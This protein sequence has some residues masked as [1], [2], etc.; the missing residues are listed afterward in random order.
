MELVEGETLGAASPAGRSRSPNALRFGLQIAEALEVA[1]ERGVIH[2]DLKPAN[3]KVTPDGRVK[4]LDFGLAEAINLP[5]AAGMSKSPTLVME[6][7]RPGTSSA[8]GVHEPEQARGRRPTAAPTSGLSAAFSSR[9]SRGAAPSRARP[10]RTRSP[11]SSTASPTGAR[12]PRARRNACAI[13]STV[14]SRRIP[15]RRLRDA[16]DARLELEPPWSG[17]RAGVRRPPRRR[18]TEAVGAVAAAAAVAVAAYLLP[19]CL[20]HPGA[21]RAAS[22]QLAVLPFR[23]LTGSPTVSCGGSRWPETVSARLADVP[24]LQVVTPRAHVEAAG[25]GPQLRQRGAEARREHAARGNPAARERPF[26]NHVSSRRRQWKPARRRGDRR[27]RALRPAGPR[28][29]Q[30]REGP[31]PAPRRGRTP[32]PSGLDTPAEQDR[33]LQAIGLL[34][35]YDLRER[36]EKALRILRKLADEKPNSALVQ[37]ALARANLAMFDFTKEREWADRAIAASDTARQLDPGLPEVDVT[38][39]QTL[40]ATGRASEAVWHSAGRSPR[41]RAT[42][43]PHRPRTRRRGRRGPGRGRGR[44]PT[45][46]RAR[47]LLR[48]LQPA[49]RVVLRLGPLRRRRG[50]VQSG[51]PNDARQLLGRSNLGG[52]ETMRCNSPAALVAFH[53]ALELAPKDPSALSNLGMTQLWTGHTAEAVAS[54]ERAARELPSDFMVLGTLG[55]AYR[56]RRAPTQDEPCL[57]ALNRPCPRTARPQPQERG[58][59]LLRRNGACEDRTHGRGEEEIGR[60]IVLGPTQPETFMDAATV[61]ALAGGDG[62][63]LDRLRRAAGAGYCR[64]IILGSPSSP[65]SETTPNSARSSPR[66]RMRPVNRRRR[67]WPLSTSTST[68]MATSTPSG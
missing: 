52:A 31:E 27:T 39:G 17:C 54:L 64:D 18:R 43:G 19:P 34:Q 4:V 50:P 5:F 51:K 56:A 16:G 35:R 26:S 66:R 46:D 22:R 13:C 21:S 23:N 58:G 30:R 68:P 29:R 11:R 20:R 32:T 33:Y 40:F 10:I 24:G 59:S 60:V 8:P 53:R 48:G 3:I 37:A 1:H 62:E 63:A 25:P 45:G 36:V 14:V 15:A 49:G 44:L 47:A 9:C 38:V 28:R 7:T 42:S 67:P 12:F 61:A 2:R 57:R 55:D 41:G 6:D 65:A